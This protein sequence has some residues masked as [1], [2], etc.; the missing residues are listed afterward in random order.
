MN[1]L[2]KSII[3]PD[4][5]Y[6]L[7]DKV[8]FL[9]KLRDIK[10]IRSTKKQIVDIIIPVYRG[11]YET[12]KCIYTVLKAPQKTAYNLIVIDDHIPEKRLRNEIYQL[13]ARGLIEVYI[14]KHNMGFPGACNLGMSIHPNR[15]VVLLNSDT[16]VYNDWLDHIR[17]AV[18]M[19][20][21]IGTATP[22]TNNAGIFS[23]PYNKDNDI[24]LEISDKDL[25]LLARK[26]NRKSSIITPTG[27]GFCLYIRRECLDSVG[28]FDEKNF[29]K[30]YGEENDLCCK[31]EKAGWHNIFLPSVFVKHHGATSFKDS[32]PERINKAI[33]IVEKLHPDY[34][35]KI[36]K[37]IKRD[38]IYPYREA[39]DVARVTKRI[40]NQGAI[41][42]ISHNWGGGTERHT[43][44]LAA[45]LEEASIPVFFL[46]ND[47]TQHDSFFIWDPH[48]QHIPNLG[49]FKLS[50]DLEGFSK[51]LKK[52]KIFHIHI[53]HFIS[54]PD[55]IGDFL[56]LVCERLKITYDVTIH[57]YYTVCPR[58]N[59]TDKEVYC[60]EPDISS[61]QSCI[62]LLGSHFGKPPVWEW[63]EKHHRV[64]K[65]ARVRFVPDLDV[66]Q[67]LKRYFRDLDFTVKEH[68][69]INLY[70]EDTITKKTIPFLNNKKTE[71]KNLNILIIGAI[72]PHKGSKILLQCA[73]I[74]ARDKLPIFFSI[75]GH[76]DRD[77]KFLKLGNVSI[78]GPYLKENLSHLIKRAKADF[79]FFSSICPE[80]YSYTLSEALR[81]KIYPVAFSIGAIARRLTE[82]QWGTILPLELIKTPRLLI[83]AL[84]EVKC[85]PAPDFILET[86]SKQR[87]KDPLH[88]YYGF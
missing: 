69:F 77:E 4:Y 55:N 49:C 83:N 10:K 70:D 20:P 67:R 58:I 38:P 35:R 21:R 45:I 52:L 84:M 5:L 18:L 13:H 78:T 86:M 30:G 34:I 41:L 46:R 79:V 3:S 33:K 47:K 66:S 87:Y 39:L 76:T 6:D 15:D 43:N 48:V 80:T 27:V 19:S 56:R 9:L 64:L 85:S 8:S 26:V 68:P 82:L 61:C 65:G 2:Q 29:N 17:D 31:I 1:T 81:E 60:G 63:R 24:I 53:H 16:E 72:G 23:Y 73:K 25:D 74:A 12:L 71:T 32:K 7:D 50:R 51:V 28:L 75:I 42:M 59:M 40:R 57:D 88:S 54:F 62:D 44:D 36:N 14:T 22:L 37:F 11:Y